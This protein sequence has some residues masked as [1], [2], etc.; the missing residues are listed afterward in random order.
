MPS[1]T[2][3]KVQEVTEIDTTVDESDLANLHVKAEQHFDLEDYNKTLTDAQKMAYT[4]ISNVLT[5]GKQLLTAV[6][7]IHNYSTG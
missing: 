2:N 7:Q 4:E 3:E 6:K 1:N 5:S